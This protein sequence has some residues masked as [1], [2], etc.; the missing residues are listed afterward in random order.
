MLIKERLNNIDFT[1]SNGWLEK[2]KLSYG[3]SETRITGE[4]D[5]IPQI[6]I[7]SRILTPA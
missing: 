7:K 4:A 2:W 6:N 5:D 1:V 3:L